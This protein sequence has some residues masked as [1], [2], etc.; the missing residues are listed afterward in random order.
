MGLSWDMSRSARDRTLLSCGI[1]K[2][3]KSRLVRQKML[4]RVPICE[5]VESALLA[6]LPKDGNQ[7]VVTTPRQHVD[8]GAWTEY[9]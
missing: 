4:T 1:C 5:I 9:K 3:L 2:H 7:P 6:Y 8:Y